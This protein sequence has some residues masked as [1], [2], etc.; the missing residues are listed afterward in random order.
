MKAL[1]LAAGLGT[2]LKPI[3]DSIPKCLVPINDKPLLSYWLDLLNNAGVNEFYINIH[4]HPNAVIEF[5]ESSPHRNKIN[6]IKEDKLLGTGG[7][8]KKN[9]H[10]FK[11]EPFFIA[12]AD[13]LCI[14]DFTRFISAH[15]SK[16]K[17][18]AI[19]M[20]TFN[21]PDPRTCGVVSIDKNNIVTE[22]HEKVENPPTTL[23]NCAVFIMDEDVAEFAS[24]YSKDEFEISLDIIPNYL[25]RIIAWHNDDYHLDIGTPETYKQ[26]QNDSN[27]VQDLFIK[28]TTP[29]ETL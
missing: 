6:I 18:T 3:T 9:A 7:T 25:E 20:M 23:A 2:R 11:D 14:T 17:N 24:N 1:L 16:P 19:T 12:H 13:N 28:Y 8:L 5:I 29:K 4:Y 22:F 21:P 10:Y 27:L 15:K 26:A